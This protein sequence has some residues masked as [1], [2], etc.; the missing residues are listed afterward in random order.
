L[1]RGAW[2]SPG[3]LLGAAITVLVLTGCHGGARGETVIAYANGLG[4]TLSG[5][6]GSRLALENINFLPRQFNGPGANGTNFAFSGAEFRTSYDLTVATQPTSPSQICV[7]YF[8]RRPDF[9]DAPR[10]CNSGRDPN[11]P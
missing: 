5:L 6:V 4:G 7:R 10:G 1:R 11:D 8:V 3:V 9:G 2:K